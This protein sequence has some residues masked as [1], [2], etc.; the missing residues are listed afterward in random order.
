M[1]AKIKLCISNALFMLICG[2]MLLSSCSGTDY[3]NA[4]PASATALLRIDASKIGAENVAS[5]CKMLLPSGDVANCG[6]DFSSNV[7]AFETVDGNFGVCASVKSVGDLEDFISSL[8]KQKR[9]G[10]L[11]KQG[12]FWFSDIN[13]SWAIG[14][15]KKAFVVVGPVTAASLPDQQRVIARMLKQDEEN[16]IVSR[17]I[18]SK[19]NEMDGGVNLVAQVQALPE[20]FVA[21]FTIG[22]PKDA[23]AS[24]VLLAAKIAKENG[25]ITLEGETFS[26]NESIEKTL[27]DSQKVYRNIVGKYADAISSNSVFC[28]YTNVDGKTFLPLLQGSKAMQSLLV[29]LNTAIDFDN[30]MRS[31]D[32]DFIIQ[33]NGIAADNLNF[34][35]LA[36]VKKPLWT[37]D[38]DYWKQSCPSGSSISGSK[39]SGWVYNSGNMK[40]YF[41]LDAGGN[42]YGTSDEELVTGGFNKAKNVAVSKAIQTKMT[43]CRLAMMLNLKA[44]SNGV[45]P[46]GVMDAMGTL[47][48]GTEAIIYTIK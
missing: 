28:L 36:Q 33:S 25:I 7:Y 42:F 47:L 8:S 3:A 24:Q 34:T 19:V 12:D 35:M 14:F 4:I 31:V 38:V 37:A 1:N 45:V 9:C 13:G 17:P 11:R 40:F 30:I 22:A 39:Q 43:G 20:K 41:G 32:G 2:V 26:F 21:P 6:L 18:F 15:S 10:A 27:K 46:G 5:V 29:G 44:I 23:D 48:G 16:S